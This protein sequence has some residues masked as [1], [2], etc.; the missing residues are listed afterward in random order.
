MAEY[1]ANYRESQLKQELSNLES[2]IARLTRPP[3]RQNNQYFEL[4][5][6]L[7]NKLIF[8]GGGILIGVALA[9]VFLSKK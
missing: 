4:D 7:I 1:R 3:Q 9:Y 8:I 6:W 2:E 5:Q